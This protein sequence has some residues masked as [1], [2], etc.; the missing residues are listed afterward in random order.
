MD[1]SEARIRSLYVGVDRTCA[2]VAIAL[3]LAWLFA[4]FSYW[5]SRKTG[6]DWFSRS[7]SVMGL[8]GAAATFHLVNVLQSALGTAL[9]QHLTSVPREIE[10]SLDPPRKYQ[11]A[12]YFS[13]LTG[14]VGTAIWGYGDQ[15]LRL[16][17]AV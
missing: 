10:V 9:K 8:V 11:I 12:T 3:V 6:F 17:S 1:T 4:G 5:L 15:V 7:G 2:R 13:Y 16:A 14:I